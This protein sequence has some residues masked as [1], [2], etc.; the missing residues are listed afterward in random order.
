[1]S[2]IDPLS[3]ALSGISNTNRTLA[4]ISQNIANANTPGYIHESHQQTALDA[5]GLP[6]GVRSGL[7][8]RDL[9]VALQ[10]QLT[11]QNAAVGQDATRASALARI[12]QVQGKPGAGGDLVA[13]IG[14]LRDSF[15]TLLT[16]PA[17]TPQQQSVVDQAETLAAQLHVTADAIVQQRQAAQDGLVADIG[18]LNADLNRIGGLSRQIIQ[19]RGVGGSTADLENQRD[20]AAQDASKLLGLKF[21]AQ[22]NGDM[23]VL[24]VSGLQLPTDGSPG[25]KVTPATLGPASYYP[26]GGAPAVTLH[27]QDVT[28][29]L[30]AG[31]IGAAATLRDTTLPTYQGSLDEFAL[32]LASRFSAQGLTLFT[33]PNGAVPTPAAVGPRQAPYVGF[34]ATISVNPAVLAQPSLVRDGTAAVAAAVGGPSSFTPNPSG[35]PAGFNSMITRVLDFALSATV[36]P[37]TPQ[38]TP[39]LAAMGPIGTLASPIAAPAALGAFATALLAGQAADAADAANIA[40]TSGDTQKALQESL[41]QSSGVNMDTE[42]AHMVQLQNAYAAN[43]RVITTMQSLWTQLLQSVQ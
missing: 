6:L 27:G 4:V 19:V 34:A 25:L 18:T 22:S 8:V 13:L 10:S 23:T 17:S 36:A 5:S 32:T 38:A 16:D 41:S 21:V 14:K 26:G 15:S 30:N 39:N 20:A 12:D 7:T 11:L 43:A 3:I 1:M 35:G 9:D 33:D 29:S 2:L 42:L 31:S 37:N 28:L 40:T 24:T